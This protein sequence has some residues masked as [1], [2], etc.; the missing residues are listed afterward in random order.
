MSKIVPLIKRVVCAVLK[1]SVHQVAFCTFMTLVL[2]Q[3]SL[4]GSQFK[5]RR[6]DDPLFVLV[7][8]AGASSVAFAPDGKVLATAYGDE[9][10][11]GGLILWDGRQG[12]LITR[13]ISGNTVNQVAFLNDQNRLVS[14][15][16]TG[17]RNDVEVWD[18]QR[19]KVVRVFSNEKNIIYHCFAVTANSPTIAL[20]GGDFEGDQPATVTLWNFE[21][22]KVTKISNYEYSAAIISL[23]FSPDGRLLAGSGTDWD[24]GKSQIQITNLYDSKNFINIKEAQETEIVQVKFSLDGKVIGTIGNFVVTLRNK[25]GHV[26]ARLMT[27]GHGNSLA[28]S[29][30]GKYIVGSY[31]TDNGVGYVR[32][33][34]F[35]TKKLIT[36]KQFNSTVVNDMAF[37]P[38]GSRLATACNNGKV[39]VWKF[40]DFISAPPE[41]VK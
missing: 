18:I 39:Q 23:G 1:C 11:K 9:K 25:K 10:M 33:W 34:R 28:F 2:C 22:G 15:V 17:R 20:G 32:V 16:E 37:S 24:L 31:V 27:A 26:L 40:L 5:T 29:P 13:L 14:L 3:D 6:S 8:P 4:A 35:D 36:S 38:D 7:C 30:D 19:R 21:S 41:K 12:K